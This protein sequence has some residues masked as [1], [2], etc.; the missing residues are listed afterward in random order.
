MNNQAFKQV[1]KTR[2]CNKNDFIVI[3][4]MIYTFRELSLTFNF[5][6]CEFEN[7]LLTLQKS[8]PHDGQ[9]THVNLRVF[10]Q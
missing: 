8:N 7:Y 10:C 2:I 9:Y 1:A 5:D 3:T 6:F 4:Y